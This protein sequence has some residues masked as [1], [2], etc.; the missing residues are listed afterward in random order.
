M[1]CDSLGYYDVTDINTNGTLLVLISFRASSA[2][3][4]IIASDMMYVGGCVSNL[5]NM[6]LCS[7]FELE[8]SGAAI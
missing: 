3:E 4:W 5:F 2:C 6:N 7:R 8:L 1:R